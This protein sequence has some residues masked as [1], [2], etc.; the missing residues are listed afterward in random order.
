[1]SKKA[2]YRFGQFIRIIGW[3][4]A[5][6]ILLGIGISILAFFKSDNGTL[7]AL[8][9]MVLLGSGV[10]SWLLLS[11]RLVY[12]CHNCGYIVERADEPAEK[13]F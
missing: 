8:S 11:Q 9:V 10:V 12:F 13:L 4:L 5:I 3:I 6:P 7:P 1:M 2:V